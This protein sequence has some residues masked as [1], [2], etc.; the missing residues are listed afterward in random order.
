MEGRRQ[1]PHFHG[2][3]DVT[4]A[5]G[6]LGASDPQAELLST[7]TGVSTE[8]IGRVLPIATTL[9][10]EFAA[11]LLLLAAATTRQPAKS[12]TVEPKET[13]PRPR[14][15]LVKSDEAERPVD[16]QM[17]QAIIAIISRS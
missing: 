6:R 3:A 14:P 17:V 16:P 10:L 1:V 12:E 9:V 15:R 11:N 7:L 8:T 4:L 13:E 2:T 5:K